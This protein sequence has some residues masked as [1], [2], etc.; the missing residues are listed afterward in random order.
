MRRF[1]SLPFLV[2][3]LTM[4]WMCA[5]S[6]PPDEEPPTEIKTERSLPDGSPEQKPETEPRKRF[7]GQPCQ[8]ESSCPDGLYCETQIP[9]GYCTREC[10]RSA[11]CPGSSLCVRIT[12]ANGLKVQRC[13]HTCLKTGDCRTDFTCYLPSGARTR[14][15]LPPRP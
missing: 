14:I 4:V 1:Q 15:C 7:V 8:K 12:F 9:Q 2:T 11:Q 13:V 6:N 5:P 3:L 10:V